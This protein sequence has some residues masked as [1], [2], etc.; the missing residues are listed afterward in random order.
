[1]LIDI[2]LTAGHD[3]NHLPVGL[4]GRIAAYKA[5]MQLIVTLHA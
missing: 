4:L 1:L 2:F 3:C 5:I